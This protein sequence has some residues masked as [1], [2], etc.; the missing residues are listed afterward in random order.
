MNV[1]T[2]KKQFILV[3]VRMYLQSYE[4]LT[5]YFPPYC[6]NQLHTPHKSESDTLLKVSQLQHT[7]LVDVLSCFASLNKDKFFLKHFIT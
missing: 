7:A 1:V 3:F 5:N 2:Q 4:Y 6:N